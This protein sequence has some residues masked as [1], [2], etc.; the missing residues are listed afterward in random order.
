M[1]PLQYI[2]ALIL[3]IALILVLFATNQPKTNTDT[4]EIKISFTGQIEPLVVEYGE[5]L[6]RYEEIIRLNERLEMENAAKS[7]YIREM[8]GWWSEW[9]SKND[10]GVEVVE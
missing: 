10:I 5:L 9:A 6:E 3:T 2:T 7:D 1:K 4:S 8:G